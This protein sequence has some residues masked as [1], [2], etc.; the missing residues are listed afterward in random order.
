MGSSCSSLFLAFFRKIKEM[1]IKKL[2][3]EIVLEKEISDLK[4]AIL[5]FDVKNEK[6]VNAQ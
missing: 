5:K 3:R 1:E 2:D 4:L 6:E